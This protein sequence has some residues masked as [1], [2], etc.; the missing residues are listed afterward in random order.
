MDRTLFDFASSRVSTESAC[1]GRQGHHATGLFAVRYLST[2]VRFFF[3]L[4]I[5]CSLTSSAHC[6]SL[7]GTPHQPYGA[8]NRGHHTGTRIYLGE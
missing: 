7:G 4:E 8:L 6:P 5:I 2:A 3:T 1:R